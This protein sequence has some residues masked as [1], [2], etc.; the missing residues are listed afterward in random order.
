MFTQYFC[1]TLKIEAERLHFSHISIAF[2]QIHYCG[3]QKQNN[4]KIESLSKYLQYE[5]IYTHGWGHWTHVHQNLNLL[6]YQ[7]FSIS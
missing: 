2:I 5:S 1:D 7:K 3:V 4:K 6:F